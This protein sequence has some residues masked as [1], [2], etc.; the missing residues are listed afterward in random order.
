MLNLIL[1][2]YY[3]YFK[4]NKIIIFLLMSAITTIS[5][6]VYPSFLHIL[7]YDNPCSF[8]YFQFINLMIIV[9][10]S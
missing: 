7:S 2:V 3:Y 5:S 4:I 1:F 9:N 10:I 6:S 8:Y